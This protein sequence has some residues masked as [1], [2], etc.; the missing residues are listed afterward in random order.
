[1]LPP[2]VILS[3]TKAPES[4]DVIIK[5]QIKTTPNI[6]NTIANGNF[7]KNTYKAVAISS[8]TASIIAIS[9]ISISFIE[10]PPNALNHRKVT[11]AG[12]ISTHKINSFMVRPLD[13]LA[14]KVP[15][16]GDQEIH[17]PQYIMVRIFCHSVFLKTS[18]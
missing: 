1:S 2:E 18:V 9:P 7:S 4:A 6:F 8:F 5:L 10:I 3:T 15:T 17:Q 11:A 12:R 13:I 14:I 16:K